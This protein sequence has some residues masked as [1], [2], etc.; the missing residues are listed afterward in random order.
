[1]EAAGILTRIAS[2]D[3]SAVEECLA[4]YSGLIW[5]IARRMCQTAADAEDAVQ[6][7][8]VELW[9]KAHLFDASRGAEATFVTMIARRR[10]IDRLRRRRSEIPAV[11]IDGAT[12]PATQPIDWAQVCEEVA[13]VREQMKQLKPD[14]RSVL[15]LALQESLSQSEIASRLDMPLGTVKS[16]ARR[17]LM[18]LRELLSRPARSP[19]VVKGGT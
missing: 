3:K 19:S 4:R 2:G 9:Q 13:I 18:R 14:E 6:D 17:G 7:I 1:L 15:A 5:T 8:F 11:S 16:H 10:L 12:E